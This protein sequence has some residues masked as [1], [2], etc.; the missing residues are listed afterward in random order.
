[1]I[2]PD[3]AHK[4]WLRKGVVR[5]FR[6]LGIDRLAGKLRRGAVVLYYHGVEREIVDPQVQ[7]IHLA[8]PVFEKQIE[9]LRR[10][11]DII[12]LNYL[13]DCLKYGYRIDP[14]S[15]LLTF[16]DGYKNNHRVVWPYLRSLEIPFAVFLSTKHIDQGT[17]FPTYCMRAALFSTERSHAYIKGLDLDLDLSSREKRILAKNTLELYLKQSPQE[18]VRRII[19]ELKLLVPEEK[20]PEINDRYQSDAPMTWNDARE[21]ASAGVAI[22]SHCHDHFILHSRQSPLEMN[23]QMKV[24]KERIEKELGTCDF[25]SYPEGGLQSLDSR[26]VLMAKEIE[27]DLGFTVVSGEIRDHVNPLILP[28]LGIS[29][30]MDHFQFNINTSFRFNRYYRDWS[31]RYLSAQEV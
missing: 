10:K 2:P 22:G 26:A 27:Y 17:R 12:S 13:R 9:F 24:S 31:L 8:F 29:S 16:D 28:R 11:C 4:K 14:A 25:I 21:L 7:E 19:D 15:V 6:W 18:S 3:R 5:S 23:E 20:W 30:D 1:M